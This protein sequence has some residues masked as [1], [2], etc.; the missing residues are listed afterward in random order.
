MICSCKFSYASL[1]KHRFSVLNKIVSFLETNDDGKV[2][3]IFWKG[4]KKQ[5]IRTLF[6]LNTGMFEVYS[7]WMQLSKSYTAAL[8]A[9]HRDHQPVCDVIVNINH[10]NH[11]T[12]LTET[13]L[14]E[15]V[16]ILT[17]GYRYCSVSASTKNVEQEFSSGVSSASSDSYDSFYDIL[18]QDPMFSAQMS[19]VLQRSRSSIMDK[20]MNPDMNDVVNELFQPT[21]DLLG[22]LDDLLHY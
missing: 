11:F 15:F 22:Q 13:D 3:D 12:R 9:Q 16:E 19:N 20:E 17:G 21:T 6:Q 1:K 18:A 2:T 10:S 7:Q 4:A 5:D 8:K 14:N